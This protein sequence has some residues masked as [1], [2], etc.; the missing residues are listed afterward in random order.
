MMISRT[1]QALGG[2]PYQRDGEAGAD[3]A[4]HFGWSPLPLPREDVGQTP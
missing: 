4:A 1:A 2:G 3:E